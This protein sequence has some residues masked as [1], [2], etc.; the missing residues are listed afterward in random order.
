MNCEEIKIWIPEYIDGTLNEDMQKEVKT[1]LEECHSCRSA[2]VELAGLISELS[3]IPQPKPPI[4]I[5][6]IFLK[7]V[8]RK[9]ISSVLLKIAAMLILALV[10]YWLGLT[11]GTKKY[12]NK[13]EELSAEINIQ[14]QN[15]LLA[16]IN[17]QSSSQKIDAVYQIRNEQDISDELISALVNTMNTD[18]N[19]NVRLAAIH[20][21]SEMIDKNKTVQKELIKSIS[22][23]ENPLLQ[24][25]LIQVLTEKGIKEASEEIE[26]ITS[27]PNADKQVKDYVESMK[28]I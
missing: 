14:K 20:S 10:T 25:S 4:K 7:Q 16:S 28:H 9:N 3:A 26:T 19:V 24:I 1:H 15:Y 6:E 18:K 5:R 11:Y 22:L 23:Q 21:L 8:P 12:N 2:E 13:I 17:E 27:N